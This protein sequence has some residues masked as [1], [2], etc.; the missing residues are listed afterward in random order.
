MNNNITN[1]YISSS[2]S[3][4]ENCESWHCFSDIFS[5][6][7][8]SAKNTYDGN[9]GKGKEYI[10]LQFPK[11]KITKYQ[12]TGFLHGKNTPTIWCLFGRLW[13]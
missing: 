10:Q 9:T 8:H 2:S 3:N 4:D 5:D 11:I 6:G 12:L 13:C 7:W 1:K